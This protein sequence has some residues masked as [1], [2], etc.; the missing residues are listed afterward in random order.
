MSDKTVTADQLRDRLA[1]KFTLPE[2]PTAELRALDAATRTRDSDWDQSFVDAFLGYCIRL[3]KTHEVP[4]E[5]RA[6][7]EYRIKRLNHKQ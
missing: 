4:A 7:L 5:Q 1:T 2:A 3:N 6:R